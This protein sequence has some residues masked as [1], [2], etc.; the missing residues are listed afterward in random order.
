MQVLNV[1][2]GASRGMGAAVALRFLSHGPLVM[3]DR[4]GDELE[5]LARSLRIAG[6]DVTTVSG[7]IRSEGTSEAVALAVR[8]S[9]LPLGR[10]CHAAGVSPTMTDWRSI[11]D[12]NLVGSA[13][14]LG[15]LDP[16][17]GEHTAAVLIASQA[18]H[19]GAFD[20]HEDVDA[21]LDD[22]LGAD[23]WP[24]LEACATG[25]VD[26]PAAAYGWSKRGVR[27]LV[28]RTAVGWGRRGARIVS[29]SP[30]IIDTPMGQI[31]FANQ[32]LMAFMV[33]STPL[34]GRQGRPDEIASVVEFLTGDGASFITGTD[35]L[36]DGGS[37]EVVAKVIRESQ[38][39]R[40]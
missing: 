36:V 32:P 28:L 14:L 9:G 25:V 6:G 10:L 23:F 15:A 34:R 22:S 38:S 21:V 7:D 17:V 30:G 35:L 26:Q 18:A 8:A 24:R 1:V 29:L 33:E 12:I 31:E 40:A 13:R 5:E 4:S 39:S 19:M 27:R 37:T 16:F 2:T 3:V 11:I 20:G